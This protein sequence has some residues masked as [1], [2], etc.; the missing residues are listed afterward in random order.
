MVV[1]RENKSIEKE[2]SFPFVQFAVTKGQSIM[3]LHRGIG[4]NL[5][6]SYRFKARKIHYLCLV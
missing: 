5:I 1:Q 6:S 3:Y 2:I 4:W